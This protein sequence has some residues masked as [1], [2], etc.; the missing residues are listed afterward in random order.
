MLPSA[1]D[2]LGV[3][4]RVMR[5]DFYE[6]AMNELGVPHGRAEFTPEVL[7]DGRVFDPAEPEEYAADFEISGLKK[8]PA[9]NES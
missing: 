2:Y 8:K 6:A 3:A 5:P 7:F 4:A 9:L 1:P